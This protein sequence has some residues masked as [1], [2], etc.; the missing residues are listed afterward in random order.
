M[1]NTVDIKRTNSFIKLGKREIWQPLN[2]K[3][4]NYS[5]AQ[6][7]NVNYSEFSDFYENVTNYDLKLLSL[8]V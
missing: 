5:Y 4:H 6:L 8:F 3:R 2:F 1:L 7:F